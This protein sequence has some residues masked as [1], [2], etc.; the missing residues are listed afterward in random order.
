MDSIILQM[1]EE[2][3]CRNASDYENAL[4]EIMQEITLLGLW[5]SKFYEHAL[6]YG[7]SALRILHGLTRFSEDLDFSLLKP[8]PDFDFS[9][10]YAAIATELEGFG[11]DVDVQS[12][13]KSI[14]SQIDSAF[15]KAGTKI[16]FIR[17][18]VPGR[19]LDRLHHNQ[20]I[21]IKLEI[22]IDPPGNHG[23]EVRDIYRP[24]PF[25]IKTMP[26]ADLFAGKI[27][28]ILARNW[29]T[30]IKGR[31]Y[32]DFLW[33]LGRNSA[34]NLKHLETRLQQSGHLDGPLTENL[35]KEIITQKFKVIN[36]E[37]AKRDIKPFLNDRERSTLELWSNEYFMKAVDRI[38]F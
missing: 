12:K 8:N 28:A 18:G 36:I 29:Q 37:N 7:G 10:Y 16:N 11:F 26:I 4:K 1:L 5:R 25:Q 31:D 33:Y 21:K 35:F 17:I 24:I 14:N 2:Y 38:Q 23:V 3:D 19:I 34:L 13:H 15:I 22:D 30:R 32:Y 9:K 27:H 6:F 20:N